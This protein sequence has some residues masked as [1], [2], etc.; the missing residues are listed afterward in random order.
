MIELRHV[1]KVIEQAVLVDVELLEVAA[2][3]I[4][5]VIGLRAPNRTALFNLLIGQTRP[6]SGTIRI[7][8]LQPDTQTRALR[9]QIGVLMAENALYTRLTV[10]ENLLLFGRLYNLPTTRIDELLHQVG[11]ADRTNTPVNKLTTSMSRRLAMGRAILHHPAV[12]LLV[13]P[14]LDCDSTTCDLL[15]RLLQQLAGSGTAVLILTG[16]A[17]GLTH[18]CQKRYVAEDGRIFLPAPLPT[19]PQTELPFKIPARLEGKVAL[20]NPGSIIYASTEEGKT[21]LHT[22][23]GRIPTHLTLA[24]LEERLSRSGFF[25][26]HRAYLVNLQH[27]T[28]V[29]S[30]TRDSYTLLLDGIPTE[31]EVPLSKNAA[32][33]LRDLLGY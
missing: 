33:E 7:A 23:N 17:A 32:K 18:L 28:E 12:L 19:E 14:F 8:G 10:R 30:Y 16:E 20:V 3:E 29:I 21:W 4:T 13:E 24:E 26:A 22:Q 11:L 27:I 15:T 6:T 1:Q 25:R 5:A 9:Q 31:T 2:G